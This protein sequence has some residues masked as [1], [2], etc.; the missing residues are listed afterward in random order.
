MWK[1]VPVAIVTKEDNVRYSTINFNN[2]KH[3]EK[4]MCSFF[5][6][7]I[8]PELRFYRLPTTRKNEATRKLL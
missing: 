5:A 4:L 7:Q 6:L 8:N 2:N 3:A 1:E